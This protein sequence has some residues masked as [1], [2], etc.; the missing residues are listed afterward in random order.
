[1]VFE[2]GTTNWV[3]GDLVITYSD[4]TMVGKLKLP[5]TASARILAVGGGGGG[6][7]VTKVMIGP[8]GG[9]GGGGGGVVIADNISLR[10]EYTISVGAGGAA[11]EGGTNVSN[12]G[13][14]GGDTSFLQNDTAVIAVA[15]GGGG[16][17]AEC[18]G[19]AGGSGGGGSM[20]ADAAQSGGS[21]TTGQGNK[22]GDGAFRYGGG[23]GGGAGAAG[24]APTSTI[25]GANGGDGIA[26][27]ITGEIV[28]YGGGG[29]GGNFYAS[30]TGK[31]FGGEG[32]GG[33]G[34]GGYYA[35]NVSADDI[36]KVNGTDGLG[37]GG[38]GGGSHTTA[39]AGKGGSG[40]LIVRITAYLDS[41]VTPPT[42]YEDLVYTGE[43]QS[44]FDPN[45]PNR[46]FYT[47]TQ[48]SDTATD[49]G[50]YSF[51]VT[52]NE[53][54]EWSDGT[55]EA[56][57]YTWS[58][59]R[60]TVARP[61]FTTEFT[62][63]TGVVRVALAESD[64]YERTGTPEATDAD[65]Y[66][67]AA[68]LK[69]N[70]ASITNRVWSD[71]TTDPISCDWTIKKAANSITGLTIA[72]WQTGATASSPSVSSVAYGSIDDVYYEYCAESA[73]VWSSVK[74]TEAGRYIVR[75]T[76]AEAD[77]W[78]GASATATFRVWR[79]PSAEYTDYIDV[80]N[81]ATAGAVDITVSESGLPGFLYDRTDGLKNNAFRF[82]YSPTTDSLHDI[83]LPY[84]NL[85]WNVSGES[86]MRVLLPSGVGTA[87]P[88]RMYW[89]AGVDEPT[90][91]NDAGA[92]SSLSAGTAATGYGLVC[93]NGVWINYWTTEPSITATTWDE[94]ETAGVISVGEL[95]I[96]SVKV[97]YQKLPG[98]TELDALPTTRGSYRA[99]LTMADMG[100]DY[101]LFGGERRLAFEILGHSPV[102]SV[103]TTAEGRI[104]LVN[105]DTGGDG[106]DAITDQGY[107]QTADT[108]EEHS[109]FWEH[110]SETHNANRNYAYLLAG[111]HHTLYSVEGDKTNRLWHIAN[112]LIGNIFIRGPQ[113]YSYANY[114]PWSS[115]SK[116]I[117]SETKAFPTR[118]DA[119]EEV[120]NI[121]LRNM[122]DAAVYS[123]C[124]TNGI[125]VVY[126][127]A[128][129]GYRGSADNFKLVVEIATETEEGLP[130]TDENCAGAN[131]L[132]EDDPYWKVRNQWRAVTILPLVKDGTDE[133]E[134]QEKREELDLLGFSGGGKTDK[135]VR[136][137]VE[138]NVR[139]PVRFRIRR[140]SCFTS[141]GAD[142]YRALL[143]LDNIIASPPAMYADLSP[144]GYY[145]ETKM[146]KQTLGQECA[147]SIPFPSASDTEV[148]ARA[149]AT[150]VVTPGVAIADTNFIASARLNY[151][152]RYLNQ[153]F[154]PAKGSDGT[155]N[156][157]TV[158]LDIENGFRSIE[159]LAFPAAEGDIEF[160]YDLTLQAPF[161][162]YQDYSGCGAAKPTGDYT[163]E[164]RSVTNR[165]DLTGLENQRLASGGTDWFVRLR[166][167]ASNWASMRVVLEGGTAGGIAGDYDMELIADNTWRAL[168]LVPTNTSETVR[169]HFEGFN[170]LEAGVTEIPSDPEAIAWG[171]ATAATNDVPATGKIVRGGTL[172]GWV[173]PDNVANYLEF[174]LNDRYETYAITRAEYQDFNHWND[175]AAGEKFK[176]NYAETNSVDYAAMQTYTNNASSWNLYVSTNSNWNETFYL[177]D[178][179]DPGYP[180]DVFY[181]RATTPNGWAAQNVSW[182]GENLVESNAVNK[183]GGLAAKLL[184]NGSGSLEFTS[185]NT[186]SGLGEVQFKTRIGQSMTFDS[187]SCRM[188]AMVSDN[189]V[190]H[191]PLVMSRSCKKDGTEIGDM[192]VGASVSLV[193]YYYQG[194]GC[195]EFRISRPYSGKSLLLE[196]YKWKSAT[197]GNAT[198]TRLA[199]TYVSSSAWVKD[200]TDSDVAGKY[201]S[202]FISCGDGDDDATEIICGLSTEPQEVTSTKPVTQ[203]SEK[204]HSGLIYTDSDSPYFC[205]SFGVG[206]KDCPA[207]FVLPSHT[208]T[209]HVLADAGNVRSASSDGVFKTTVNLDLNTYSLDQGYLDKRQWSKIPGRAEYFTNVVTRT[210]GGSY[211]LYGLRTPI[212]L[213]QNL[214]VWLSPKGA[215]QWALQ[216]AVSVSGFAFSDKR[217]VPVHRTGTF[218][219]RLKTGDDQSVDVVVDDIIQTQWQAP[220]I[221][222]DKLYNQGGFIYTQGVVTQRTSSVREVILQP[223]RALATS[224]VSMRSP[225][226]SGLGKF[227]FTYSGADTNA[228]IWVQIATNDVSRQMNILNSSLAEG[229]AAGQWTTIGKFGPASA[230]YTGD[231]VLDR[232][233][234]KVVYLGW[235]N[236]E[237]RPV[238]GVFRLFVPTNVVTAALTA[239]TNATPNLDYGRIT[240]TGIT[241]TDE[242]GISERSWRGWNMR[243]VGDGKDTEKRMYLAD[244]TQTGGEGY[245]LVC[246]LNNGVWPDDLETTNDMK[247]VQS[248]Y[249]AVYSPTFSTNGARRVGI[250]SVTYRARLYNDSAQTAGGGQVIGYGSTDPLYGK[251]VPIFTNAV[252]SPVFSDFSWTAGNESYYAVKFEITG[253]SLNESVA[254]ESSAVDRV[255]LDEIFVGE[256]VQPTLAFVYARPFRNNL[257][258][259]EPVA[260]ILSVNEQPLA[261]ESWGVQAQLTLQQLADEV[262]LSRGLKVSLSY[263]S[264]DTPWGYDNWKS[265][266]TAVTDIELTQVGDST[267][268][269]FRSVGTTP[270][271]LVPPAANAGVVVQ[272]MLKVT[273][274]DRGGRE[275]ESLM[276]SW[277]Q[278]TWYYP[279]DLNGTG[280]GG[281]DSEDFSKYSAYTILDSVSPGRA[282]INEVNW[283]DGTVSETDGKLCET[284]QFIEIC[285]PSGADMSGWRVRVR[286]NNNIEHY[287][288]RFGDTVPATTV[289]SK[290]VNGYEFVVLQSPKSRDAGGVTNWTHLAAG[291]VS[292]G[293][294]PTNVFGGSL[295]YGMPYQF[296]LIRPSGIIEHQFVLSGTNEW[297][298]YSFGKDYDGTN[299]V[300]VLNAADSSPL[301][302]YAGD[303]LARRASGELYGSAGVTGGTAAGDP[304]PGAA[305]TWKSGLTFTPGTVNEGQ[306]I[307]EGWVVHPNGTN[308]WVYLNV[309]GDHLSQEI[310][311]VTNRSAVVI[312][313]QGVATNVTYI[314]EPW[315]ELAVLT[316]NG[317]TNAVNRPG[318]YLHT[319]TPTGQTHIVVAREGTDNRLA[320]NFGLDDAN[321]YTPAVLN[322]LR[323][324]WADKTA[325]DIRLAYYRGLGSM[326]EA[327]DLSLTEMYWLDIPPVTASGERE[328]WLRGDMSNVV[329]DTHVIKRIYGGKEYYMTNRIVDVML[330]IT[331]AVSGTVYA[332]YRLQGVDN[333]QS[334]TFAGNMWTSVTF[335]VRAALDVNG[336]GQEG[337]KNKGYLPFRQF[338]FGTGSF[339]ENFSARIEIDDPFST[340]SPG[341]GYGWSNYPNTTNMFFRWSI[342]TDLI[343]FAVPVLK[344]NDTYESE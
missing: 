289:T 147:F 206:A 241:V 67:C 342:D 210:S 246:G 178:Y 62:Y 132:G 305:G 22:G 270:A 230:G 238:K 2:G 303:E 159:P 128:V 9:G 310:G 91:A 27:D 213:E 232:A 254:P 261:G 4:P 196:L 290:A 114:L 209:G 275:Y 95:K 40:V 266:S 143:L 274:Y 19:L 277:T 341:Y 286:N 180:K 56:K 157:K 151:R 14:T 312:V 117:S 245:G 154:S 343:P 166:R 340:V 223:S 45:D 36:A 86:T 55:T 141:Y 324:N 11:G 46:A 179:T 344:A 287:L 78:E 191:A 171:V 182:V 267:N 113:A 338:T 161:Y 72:D 96:G 339:D 283:N 214:E 319:V 127:D 236:N 240:I 107:W 185:A 52:L 321:V 66:E 227:A 21:G 235:H 256:K 231:S 15:K 89:H 284:N 293:T 271:E 195:Y 218:D 320:S 317:V 32:G 71:G 173:T 220:N 167:G 273:Y 207:Q 268:L 225:L 41:G 119:N 122:T 269:L 81:A 130:P 160:F 73:S 250:G 264:G 251:W 302:F 118:T 280:T 137:I 24:V 263:Y 48:G 255:I 279:I 83:L 291:D 331:N 282:W 288:A 51:T 285:V 296:E 87:S 333:E 84:S 186:P 259:T 322:W 193:A 53:G 201:Y 222:D 31:S 174:K 8:G 112:G 170:E 189:Y 47:V 187:F 145:D 142:D 103:G 337:S 50:S 75:A 326:A 97:T 313:P 301:R 139:G 153:R 309:I 124:Y 23:G 30:M 199:Y 243:T 88:I 108:D 10:G 148:Y 125:G 13:T 329:G 249:P 278:P 212:N 253:A 7:R 248:G 219:L 169:F 292:L 260:D 229:A 158:F 336:M 155:D 59:A 85:T 65:D 34:L 216:D 306:V 281:Y 33:K 226:L 162:T 228:E 323:S 234:P 93:S 135:F 54:L 197:G 164:L 272:F 106:R 136:G 308:S 79:N 318:T 126:F 44:A 175:A 233:V 105:D 69:G 150:N 43:E 304:A 327:V 16:G 204:E 211:S 244:M 224:P 146:G 190:F 295:S 156:W 70:S 152:W 49:T 98:G 20:L 165:M 247:R 18:A 17:G 200:G 120:G 90:S 68:V 39:V 163:E 203:F 3:E 314:A 38:G 140:S 257:M 258:S 77:N 134:A 315:Y 116:S 74:P 217:T 300:A 76:L 82:V 294:W 110:S 149:T 37:G 29:G 12:P 239:A 237:D 334:D 133:F 6:G 177:A 123:P 121:V 42:V 1:M 104:L 198:S 311:G 144:I 215:N 28:S 57:T 328:W 99:V 205:G 298:A 58:I 181:Q 265:Q 94:G 276:S 80:T 184:G 100:A 252:T 316:E 63:E 221:E 176:I 168:V 102:S 109:I 183:S 330:Y 188:D 172:D 60:Q 5:K 262:D 332:P 101:A 297:A 242:P 25:S 194:I 92:V 131:T 138:V 61:T 129:N 64:D 26:S 325:E 192:A 335:K 202:A 307:P 35:G 115:T 111:I 208:E 299:L